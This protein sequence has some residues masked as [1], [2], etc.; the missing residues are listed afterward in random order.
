MQ[1]FKNITT[2]ELREMLLNGALDAGLTE[3]EDYERLFD[4]EA[5]LA[6]PNIIVFEFC[7]A[8]LNQ[9]EKYRTDIQKPPFEQ[10]LARYNA[11]RTSRLKPLRIII[12]AALIIIIIAVAA[13]FAFSGVFKG[14]LNIPVLETTEYNGDDILRTNDLKIYNSISEMLENENLNILY[15][16]KLPEGYEFA[17][18]EIINRGVDIEV[19]A[20]NLNPY[21]DFR[22]N[23]GENIYI[24]NY[25]YEVNNIKFRIDERYN[26]YYIFWNT[27]TD[28]YMIA[29][30]DEAV[31]Y[32]IINNLKEH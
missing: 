1:D 2:R 23:L 30:D 15:P 4:Y 5:E 14:L 22:I 31:I 7:N 16:V 24:D 6:E 28:Y 32:E 10:I 12:A 27:D 11:Q 8:G 29:A 21:I 19:R 3:L 13:G 9:Y 18:F 26:R 20:Y 25:N 17:N